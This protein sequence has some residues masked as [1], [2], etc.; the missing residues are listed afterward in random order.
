LTRSR[1]FVEWALRHGVALWAV[2]LILGVPAFARTAW[3][4]AHLRSELEEL[5]PTESPSVVALA[6]LKRRLGLH[7]Y[8]GVVVDA[9]SREALPVAE[10]FL[11][12]LADRARAY[13]SGLVRT[14]RTGNEA[15]VE[16]L[17]THGALYLDVSDLETLR[18]RVEAKR[19]YEVARA[20]GT[21]LDDTQPPPTIDARD[22]RER[23]EKRLGRSSSG[24]TARYT[25][26]DEPWSVLLL[27]LD[28]GGASAAGAR[29]VVNRVKADV[30]ALRTALPR[31]RGMRIGYAGD[32]AIATEELSALVADLSWSSVI[33]IVAVVLVI[34]LYYRWWRSVLVLLPPLLLATFYSFGLASLPPFNVSA[35]NSNTAFLASIIVGNGINFGLILLGRYVEERRAGT[36]VHESIARAVEGGGA[37]ARAPAS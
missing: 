11:D 17:K 18:R 5:L 37:G 21:L 4:Y 13:P 10:S 3:L 31:M 2:A 25:S 22:I 8:L 12:A 6:S 15:E 23:Y 19:D 36:G 14:V 29:D 34:V 33:V 24:A 20:T 28:D 35:V 32:A 1:R 27:E 30:E 9:G 26:P 16:F 7:K